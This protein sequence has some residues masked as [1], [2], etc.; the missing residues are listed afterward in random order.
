MKLTKSQIEK[1]CNKLKC[2]LVS[3]S[4]LASGNHNG[5]YLI[6]GNNKNYV[7]K[8]GEDP[9]RLCEE[10]DTLK[11]LKE[12]LGPR[13]YFLDKSNEILPKTFFIEEF[14]KLC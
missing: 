9:N 13:V 1:V 8:I 6:K 3:Y 11:K 5:I 7:M 4:Y 12:G 2:S 10:F 14:L